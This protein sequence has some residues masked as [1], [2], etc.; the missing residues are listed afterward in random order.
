MSF[1]HVQ[2]CSYQNKYPHHPL[3]LSPKAMNQLVPLNKSSTFTGRRLQ[4]KKNNDQLINLFYT[5]SEIFSVQLTSS[6]MTCTP[7]VLNLIC[8]TQRSV[9]VVCSIK[10]N[11]SS[12]AAYRIGSAST[13][14]TLSLCP[15]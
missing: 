14:I 15:L 12:N 9:R 3:P 5:M 7:L 1:K 2:K 6:D 13:L 4:H 8:H 10:H 11:P